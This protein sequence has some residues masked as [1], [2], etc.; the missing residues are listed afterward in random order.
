[1]GRTPTT[2]Q[3]ICTLPQRGVYGIVYCNVLYCTT[4][5]CIA[6][7][8]VGF[9]FRLLVVVATSGGG[10]TTT[11]TDKHGA[12]SM[13]HR[14]LKINF[15][16]LN[17][18]SFLPVW[19]AGYRQ[20]SPCTPSGACT[21]VGP[22][23]IAHRIAGCRPPIPTPELVSTA[24]LGPQHRTR[25]RSFRGS[26]STPNSSHSDWQLVRPATCH[27]TIRVKSP[28]MKRAL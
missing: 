5:Y 20:C 14:A 25:R 24:V 18:L 4:F 17:F 8:W 7:Y 27:S 12:W 6:L 28:K 1:M 16:R 9:I 13:E 21:P 22:P 26:L 2:L 23:P 11:T 15:Q 19:N 3:I 10:T